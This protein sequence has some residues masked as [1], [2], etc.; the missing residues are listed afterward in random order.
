MHDR[1]GV[2][3]RPS[4]D[5]VWIVMSRISRSVSGPRAR[6]WRS[7]S[8]STNSETRNRERVVIADLVD[9]QDVRMIERRGG[10]R[11]VQEAAEPLGIAAQLRPQHLERDRPAERRIGGLVDLA[12]AA[13]AEQVLDL[14]AADGGPGLRDMRR[15]NSTVK[16]RA[17][18][19]RPSPADSRPQDLLREA[20]RLGRQECFLQLFSQRHEDVRRSAFRSEITELLRTVSEVEQL[21]G[22]ETLLQRK[23]RAASR[24][25]TST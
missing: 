17:M 19:K 3:A 2:C 7:V 9:G 4:A 12:H 15:G 25:P 5:A 23:S 6:R 10:P 16:R 20:R 11:L 8:P 22:T 1:R 18:P 14:I 24:R 13:A 21:L